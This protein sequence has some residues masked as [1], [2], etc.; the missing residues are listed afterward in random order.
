MVVGVDEERSRAALGLKA[1]ILSGVLLIVSS[2]IGIATSLNRSDTTMAWVAG[3][4]I[5][6][7]VPYVVY[8]GVQLRKLRSASD[9]T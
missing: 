9:P 1:A 8:S 4:P 7:F 3:L 2:A 5:I 6:F